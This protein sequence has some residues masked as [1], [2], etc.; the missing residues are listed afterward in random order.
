MQY[1]KV[2]LKSCSPEEYPDLEITCKV[3]QN[4]E[5]GEYL[6]HIPEDKKCIGNKVAPVKA[7]VGVVG[8]TVTSVLKTNIDGRTYIISEES[9]TVK[10][11]DGFADVVVTNISST[12]KE[13]YVVRA[14][15]FESTYEPNE[16]KCT[17]TPKPDPRVITESPENLIIMTL[18][19]S[20]AICLKGSYIVT[21]NADENDYNTL[22]RGAKES[23]YVTTPI[24]GKNKTLTK[25]ND[26]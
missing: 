26:S 2:V 13:E 18:W 12:S 1:K 4:D 15:K 24:E 3:L 10:E 9:T 22:E 6:S 20:E 7:R 5:I 25:K 14:S 8:E 17:Y 11:K 23:T 19:G 16:S 21:Y